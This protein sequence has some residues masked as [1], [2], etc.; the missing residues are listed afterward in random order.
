MMTNSKRMLACLVI[1]LAVCLATAQAQ[2]TP[3][4]VPY[5]VGEQLEFSVNWTVGNIGTAWMHVVAVDSF[6][7]N[8]VFRI[9]AGANSNKT[10][11]L[12][13]PVRDRFVSLIDTEEFFPHKFI[14]HQKE[15]KHE[16]YHEFIFLQDELI[17]FDLVK[18]DTVD[19][20]YQQQDELSIFY[21]FRTL[22]LQV[23]RGLLLENFVDK[24]GNPLK[25]AVVR[26]EWVEVPAGRFF[27]YVV[28]PYIKSGGLFKHKGNL[29]IWITA[30]RNRIPVKV[31]S[32]LDIGKILVLLESYKLGDGAR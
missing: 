5:S 28:E 6:G 24:Q 32:N 20:V 14:K 7:S 4:G 1:G 18:G 27:C 15:G 29:Q 30:D 19:I 26:T 9:E 31:A 25:V 22:D 23:G 10:I 3:S 8:Q 17:R 16:E 2:D 12:F 13:Y 11:D 21:Y